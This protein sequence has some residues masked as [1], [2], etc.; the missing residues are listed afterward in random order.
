MLRSTRSRVLVALTAA[1]ALI[2]AQQA[3]EAAPPQR[4][5][6]PTVEGPI[7]GAPVGAAPYDPSGAG[8]VEEEFFV[9]GTARTYGVE[10]TRTAPYRVRILV[11]R[12]TP[13]RQF[14]GTAIVEW[15]NVSGQVPGGHPMFA[16]LDSYAL[17]NGYAF[18]QVA[19]QA[20]PLVAG[21]V[22][23][24]Q[25][26][27]QL[28]DPARYGSLQHPGD[29]FS[30]DIFSQAMV[31]LT[32]RTGANPMDGLRVR[33]VIATGNS[34][35]ASRLHSYLDLVQRDADVADAVLLDAGGDKTFDQ[36]L[37][38]PTIHLLSE[39]G[40]SPD[41]PNRTANYRLW[42]VPGA[43][44][45]DADLG[46]NLNAVN[47]P[48]A[49]RRSWSEQEAF[50]DERH[51]GEEG[52]SPHA[53]CAPGPGGNEYPRRYAVAA[54]V[55]HLNRSIRTGAPV[56]APPRVDYDATGQP[57]RDTY[58]NITGGVRLPP[59]DVPVAT[60]FG[61]A[62]T[63]FG[64]NVPLDPITLAELYPNH[65]DYVAKMQAATDRA[66]AAGFLLPRDAQELMGLADR[67]TI[68]G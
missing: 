12:P 49:P 13:N 56:P 38:V 15:E 5:P 35:S 1:L 19:A 16:W 57:V 54:A 50:F 29:D 25:L 44:H 2:G 20:T 32:R 40:F 61:S 62:C 9:S 68:G 33:R 63:L 67:S 59:L 41:A 53:T 10:P 24:G 30:Y 11:Y 23:Q 52:L 22:G 34:Q 4:V 58:G 7:P 45:S 51:Y 42:E 6:S 66:V 64:F 37:A 65:D 43:S 55:H 17:R 26:G 27:F 8:Y 46:R 14:N 39:D 3:V 60:Y 36:E 31:A 47:V 28:F 48:G 18:V 21:P